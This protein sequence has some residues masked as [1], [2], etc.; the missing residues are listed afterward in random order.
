MRVEALKKDSAN[1]LGLYH[2]IPARTLEIAKQRGTPTNSL[3][4]KHQMERETR[5]Y[6]SKILGSGVQKKQAVFFEHPLPRI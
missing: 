5:T 2:Q 3:F 4:K 6:N 1:N